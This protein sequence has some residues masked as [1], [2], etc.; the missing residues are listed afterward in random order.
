MDNLRIESENGGVVVEY[1]R[2]AG[3]VRRRILRPDGTEYFGGQFGR[4]KWRTVPQRTLDWKRT[5][6][7]PVGLWLY[8]MEDTP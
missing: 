8:A 6:G 7:D 4:G 5:L 2:V 3:I 1:A